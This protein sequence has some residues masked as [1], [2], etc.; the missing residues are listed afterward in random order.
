MIDT[1]NSE[2]Y[3]I[4]DPVVGWQD[5][6]RKGLTLHR[7]DGSFTLEPLPGDAKL[8]LDPVKE[9]EFRCPAALAPEPWGSLLVLDAALHRVKRVHFRNL[10]AEQMLSPGMEELSLGA[11]VETLPALGREG[12]QPR[13]FREPRGV[14]L[15]PSGA[16]VVADT[17][18]HRVQVFSRPP[19]ALLQVWGAGDPLGRPTPGK[20]R[21]QF[22]HPWAVAA[23]ECGT[24]Y[25]V[26]RGNHRIQKIASDGAWLGELGECFLVDPTRLALGPEGLIG[27]VDRGQKSV[28]LFSPERSL[29]L[30]VSNLG[31]PCSIAFDNEGR[32]YV[33]DAIGRIYVLESDPAASG[34]Y[35]TVG[36]GVTGVAGEIVDLAWDRTNG[37]LAIIHESYNGC[38]QRTWRIDP[39]AAFATEGILFTKALDSGIERCQWHRT[40]FK[41]TVPAGT[42]LRVDSYTTE[43]LNPAIDVTDAE[44]KEWKLCTLTGD[45]DPD[46]LV[47]SGPGR[48]LSLRLTFRSSGSQSP[49]L[50][51]IKI[52]FP[53]LSYLQY[54]PAVFQE[55]EGSRL[56]LERFLSIFQTEFD[57]LDRRIDLLWQLFDP[58]SDTAQVM[59]H[60]DRDSL[61]EQQPS[62]ATEDQRLRWLAG[63]LALVINPEWSEAKLRE[64][65]GKAYD[66][67]CWRGTVGGLERAVQDY[68]GVWAKVIEHF[69]L[70]HWPVLA[71][72]RDEGEKPSAWPALSVAAPLDGSV[73]LWSRDFYQRLQ[74]TSYSQLGYFRLTG[75]PEPVIEPLDWASYKF[76]VFFP[77]DPYHVEQIQ[78][79]VAAVV[80]REKPAH[81][82]ATLC[83]VYP[84]MRVGVQA[85]LGVDSVVGEIS[86][87]VLNR[88]ATLNYDTIL[89]CSVAEQ[90]IRNLGSSSRPR[91]GVSMR[92]L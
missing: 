74:L 80:E 52:F 75:V 79:Q 70:R 47:Q 29:P 42:S 65:L 58:D 25:I 61:F 64:M 90:Q 81:T 69:R 86:Y 73:R 55:D 84:R 78:R 41:A 18:N 50:H 40:A 30:I 63:W 38:R 23:D 43:E 33:G 37:L 62:M 19:Y 5:A 66:D 2:Q 1:T 92:L 68:T 10:T 6:F 77:A 14:A 12:S 48:Y 34:H 72:I 46:C 60:I 4:L 26:D 9:K 15:L 32:V 17:G 44:F 3:R 8:L 87:L 35:L 82:D 57:D 7:P 53:R 45:V 85:T 59:R 36:A 56:F 11:T 51:S 91:V 49:S 24:V 27:V 67:Y 31:E 22:R 89:A 28:L 39:A 21:K 20:G 76:T 88:L 13:W 71:S 16:I 54:L 83:P